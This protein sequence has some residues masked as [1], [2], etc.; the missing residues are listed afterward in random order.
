LT[1]VVVEV[2]EER[3]PHRLRANPRV[4]KRAVLRDPPKRKQHHPWPQ[5]TK[6]PAEAVAIVK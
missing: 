3:N 4:L 5:P 2:L 1:E 6:R